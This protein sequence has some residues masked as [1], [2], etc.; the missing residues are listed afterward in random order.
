VRRYNTAVLKVTGAVTL[1]GY[2]A[3]TFG[4]DEKT[5]FAA[6]M[7]GVRVLGGRYYPPHH[8]LHLNPRFS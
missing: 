4:T 1:D 2:T 7:V 8:S 6:G 3:E 5:A